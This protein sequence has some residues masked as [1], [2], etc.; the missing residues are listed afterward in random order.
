MSPGLWRQNTGTEATCLEADRC[1]ACAL[2][3]MLVASGLGQKVRKQWSG[4]GVG[5]GMGRPG[6]YSRTTP[7]KPLQPREPRSLR[8]SLCGREKGA[9][10][11]ESH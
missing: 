6:R 11:R 3:V 7:W 10:D 2:Q 1:D 9:R 4:L 5:V 8:C